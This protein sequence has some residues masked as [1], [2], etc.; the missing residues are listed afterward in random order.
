MGKSP[1]RWDEILITSK[2]SFLNNPPLDNGGGFFSP[3]VGCGSCNPNYMHHEIETLEM[4]AHDLD[5]SGHPGLT[6][7]SSI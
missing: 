6:A 2:E 3:N 5:A 1:A 4:E 7:L